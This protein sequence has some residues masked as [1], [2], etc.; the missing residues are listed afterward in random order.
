MAH[1]FKAVV[2][3]RDAPTMET[4][5]AAKNTMHFPA[6]VRF[7]RISRYNIKLSARTHA[8]SLQSGDISYR[9]SQRIDSMSPEEERHV[10]QNTGM[11]PNGSDEAK[12]KSPTKVRA[13]RSRLRSYAE[14]KK[15]NT[16][17][18]NVMIDNDVGNMA[19][20]E[21]GSNIRYNGGSTKRKAQ[22]QVP[23]SS[24]FD[25]TPS[26]AT[27]LV[28][29]DIDDEGSL[30]LTTKRQRIWQDKAVQDRSSDVI[31]QIS[32]DELMTDEKGAVA[33]AWTDGPVNGMFSA[34]N[35]SATASY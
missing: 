33:E 19:C 26:K 1:S 34:L 32:E 22:R 21:T 25:V 2:P 18:I 11:S 20:V 16:T 9:L 31:D 12:S 14:C 27:Q 24:V 29:D 13:A 30:E 35:Y 8:E 28:L 5:L 4:T 17:C 3:R 7:E 15:E 6:G 10:P 23:I